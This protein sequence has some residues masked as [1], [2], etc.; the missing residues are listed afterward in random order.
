MDDNQLKSPGQPSYH[1]FFDKIMQY[2]FPMY[3]NELVEAYNKQRH[4]R[5]IYHDLMRFRV[6]EVLLVGS[7]YDSFVV[8]SDG[9]LTEQIYGEYFKLN[10]NTI[11]RVVCTYTEETALDL[12]R[13][14]KF[15]LVILMAG[16]DFD[17]PLAIAKAMKHIWPDIPILLMATN[18]SSLEYL[19]F[20]SP[21][22]ASIDRVF[23]WN[24]YSKLFVGMIKYIEDFRNVH[25]D[26]QTGQVRVILLIEDSVRYYSRYLPVLYKV[27]LRQTQNLIEEERITETYKLL[28]IRARPKIL[29]ASSYEE[30]EKL[31]ETYQNNLLTVITDL[32]FPHKGKCDEEAGFNFIKMAKGKIHDLP[33]LIQSS[34]PH[35]R[36]KAYEIGASFVDKNSE[37]LE[38]ELASFLQMNLGFGDFRFCMP[39]GTEIG[40]ARNMREFIAKMHELPAE[41]LV[42]HAEHNHF[43]AWLMARGEIQMSKVLKPYQIGDFRDIHAMRDFIL[44]ILDS[45]RKEKSKGIVP[46]FDESMLHEENYISRLMDG[47]VGGKGRGIMFIHSLLENLDFSRYIPEI[48]IKIPR[49]MFI[50]IDEFENFLE[51]HNLWSEAFYKPYS[52]QLRQTFLSTPLSPTLIA[53]LRAFLARTN[54]PLA[55]RSSG[56]FEDMLMVPFSGIYDTYI[57]PNSHPDLEVR[58]NQVCDAIKLI[59]ASLFSVESRSYFETANYNLEEERMAVLIQELVGSRHGDYYFPHISGIAQSYN[60]YPVS[61]VKPE[62]GLCISALGLGT[63]VVGGGVAHHFCPK[64]PKLDVLSPDHALESTQR[65]FH[66][67]DMSIS[68]PDLSAGEMASLKELDVSVAN[69]D[70]HFAMIASTW[71]SEDRRFVPGTS[72]R[73]PKIIDLANILKYEALP[74]AQAIAMILEIGSRSM[75][76]PVEIEYALNLSEPSGKPALYILQLKPLIQADEKIELNL[77][78]LMPEDCFIISDKTMGNGRYRSIQDIVW[79]DPAKFDKAKTLEMAAEIEEID[80]ELKKSGRLY[81]L[82]G[83]GRWGTRDRWLGIPVSFAQISRAKVIVEVDLDNFVIDSSL[84]SHFFHNLTSM[85]IGYIK[86]PLRSKEACIDWEWLKNQK[87][88]METEHCVWSTLSAPMDILMDGKQGKAGLLKAGNRK[89]PPEENDE[90]KMEDAEYN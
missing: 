42:Y 43:S 34:E 84:G 70:H 72:G 31:F 47:S 85:N 28:S 16:L 3:F 53:R 73:G 66:A 62:D 56:L 26:T 37:S 54:K 46:N 59:Y 20:D 65:I 14:G 68:T 83:P 6:R 13:S 38:L 52:D 10:L 88:A 8:E 1:L 78:A 67:L 7:L 82:I 50:G 18:N 24:G 2:N 39:D 87:R 69:D 45:V 60:Y 61:Y 9:V 15:D 29:L 58:L 23:V 64:Y 74:F 35:I 44:K 57:I 63:Y 80:R 81:V 21:E 11:P 48:D 79:V 30:A 33:V 25:A 5:N 19:N 41:S 32:R 51:S 36:S 22:M 90:I 89:R 49:T 71:D 76:T 4:D 17:I 77:G 27:V 75:G 40:R 55:V 86:I 12:F